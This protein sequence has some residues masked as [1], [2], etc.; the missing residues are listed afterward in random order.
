MVAALAVAARV[1]KLAAVV[2]VP[3]ALTLGAWVLVA[4]KLPGAAVAAA[5]ISGTTASAAG[6]RLAR[7]ALVRLAVLPAARPRSSTDYPIRPISGG[8]PLLQVW[9]TQ[10][11]AAF[12]WLEVKC[13]AGVYRVL[14]VLTV[15]IFAGAGAALVARAGARSTGAWSSFLALACLALLA[16]LHWTDYHQLEAGSRGFMQGALPVPGDRG[17]RR[18]ARGRGVAAS[19]RRVRPAVAGAHG[20]R[21]VRLPPVRVRPRAVE[22]LCVDAR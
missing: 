16:G 9:I 7:D 3:L 17:V 8:Y 13:A 2:A 6:D 10:G 22:V 21:A 19:R 5:Q 20:R 11:W 1:A 12:G 14:G 18:R 4:A 15:A